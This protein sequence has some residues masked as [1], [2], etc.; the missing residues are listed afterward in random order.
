MPTFNIALMQL[1]PLGRAA[2]NFKKSVAYCKE[3]KKKGAHLVLL[4]EIWQL[5][6]DPR[7]LNP[8][9]AIE[10]ND[11]FIE[12]YR[13]LAKELQ[14]AIAVTYLAACDGQTKNQVTIFDGKGEPV[15]S[16][17][18][19]HIC[20][21]VGGTE[22]SLVSGNAFFVE[23]LNYFDGEVVLGAM[24]CM[25]REFPES[26]RTLSLK[27]AEIV[28][29]PN[30]CPVKTCSV[31][32]DARLAGL[33]ALSYENL[34]GVAMT[35]YPVPVN[36]GHSCAFDNLGKPLVMATQKE[37]IWIAPFDLHALREVRAKEWACR[38]APARKPDIY[39]N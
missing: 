8:S 35:N 29:V 11:P 18:K 26:A 32:G 12:A 21:F 1:A 39:V 9:Y 24:I 28:I 15:L 38:G 20:D 27:G 31:L 33:R 30:A 4:P 23:T 6:Y 7:Y 2:Q 5:G 10:L 16:Y 17:A 19:V 37:G 34:I 14:M 13:Q 36:D 22:R 3:A 25:D